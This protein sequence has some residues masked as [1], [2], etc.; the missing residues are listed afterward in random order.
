MTLRPTT[1]RF[2]ARTYDLLQQESSEQGVSFAQYVRE[3]VLLRLVVDRHD[4]D[5]HETDAITMIR[6]IRVLARDS[7]DM[8]RRAGD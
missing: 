8:D 6:A 1:I 3:A 4:R 5:D 2:A 7:E